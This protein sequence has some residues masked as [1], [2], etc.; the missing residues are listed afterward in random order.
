VVIF[1]SR[2]AIYEF[3]HDPARHLASGEPRREQLALAR[4]ARVAQHL[5]RGV[6]SDAVAAREDG[7]RIEAGEAGGEPRERRLG[8]VHAMGEREGEPRLQ[9]LEQSLGVAQ[10]R[11][12]MH[13]A[14]RGAIEGLRR[15][16]QPPAHLPG[17]AA[18]ALRGFPE[19]LLLGDHGKLRRGGRG[20]RAA[21][22]GEV[23]DREVGLVAYP[24]DDRNRA[25]AQ[26]ARDRLLVEGP[27][28]LDRAAAAHQQQ[29]VAFGARARPRQH[30]GDA[31]AR[32]STLNRHRIDDDR[33]RGVATRERRQHVAQRRGGARGDDADGA[34]MLRQRPLQPLVEEPFGV[35]AV[36]EAQEAL[37]ERPQ[38]RRPHGFDGELKSPARL[39]EGDEGACFDLHA[40]AQLRP[41]QRRPAAEHHA[42]DLRTAVLEREVA[43]ARRRAV[44]VGEL[45]RHPGER[46][47]ALER[48]AHAAQ[49]LRHGQDAAGRRARPA[50]Q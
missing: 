46:K 1:E 49:Q 17:E 19:K 8:A 48:V 47:A 41:E 50:R 6:A 27:Q 2:C 25:C 23:G 43:V 10:T 9:L 32:A 35:E 7:R 4:R 26:R 15:I 24:D 18:R 5:A 37:E 20:R 13:Q 29:H 14:A 33:H 42:V 11:G 22:R 45:A 30:G 21:V 28:V 3:L 31:L 34:R 38:A 40:L 16:L 44:E 12:G 39:V 36:L